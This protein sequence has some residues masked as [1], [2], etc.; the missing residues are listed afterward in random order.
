MILVCLIIIVSIVLLYILYRLLLRKLLFET[1]YHKV[2]LEALE[3]YFAAFCTA[4][5]R[6]VIAIT[7]RKTGYF[8]QFLQV[9]AKDDDKTLEMLFGFPEAEWSAKFFSG[10]EDILLEHRIEFYPVETNENLGDQSRMIYVRCGNDCEKATLISKLVLFD[11]FDLDESDLYDIWFSDTGLDCPS[12]SSYFNH[13]VCQTNRGIPIS[14]TAI[15]RACCAI[16]Y[17]AGVVMK[18]LG[19]KRNK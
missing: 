9:R 6:S 12:Y 13:K 11:V 18:I 7:H 14:T 10:I 8:V 3:R 1:T 5:Y 19:A 17:F 15:Y 4:G 16:G 2:T